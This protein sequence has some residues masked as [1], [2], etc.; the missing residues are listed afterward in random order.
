MV[1]LKEELKSDIIHFS[2]VQLYPIPSPF[3]V[4][5]SEPGKYCSWCRNEEIHKKSD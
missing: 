2:H 1:D 3:N 4:F 5:D